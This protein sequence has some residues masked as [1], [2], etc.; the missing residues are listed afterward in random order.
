MKKIVF[1]SSNSKRRDKNSNCT[2]FPKWAEQWDDMAE[3]H[4]DCEVTLVVQLNGRYFLDICNGELIQKP[5]KVKLV[6]L[7]M[8]AKLPEFVEAVSAL[9]PDIAVAMTGPVSGY[10]WNGIRDASIAD[11]LRRKGIDTIC[12]PVE[13]ALDCF[14]KWR[15]HQVFVRH[16]F[17]TPHSL[18]IHHELF[19]SDKQSKTCTGN[20]YQEY[21][22]YEIQK[23]TM[24]VVI[25]STTGSSSMGIYVAKNYED[26]KKYLMSDQFMEDVIV[27]EFLDGDEYSAEVH[28]ARG[29][30]FV[31]PI[32]QVFDANGRGLKDPLGMTTLKYGPVM[33]AELHIEEIRRELL[34][35]AEIMDFSGIMNIDL[36]FVKGEWYIFEVNNRWSGVT[37]LTTASQGR[38]PYDV[39]M[40][41]VVGTEADYNDMSKMSFACQFKMPK[42]EPAVMAG[43]AKEPSVQSIIQYEVRPANKDPFWFNDVVIGGFPS[44]EKMTERFEQLSQKYPEQV[45]PKLVKALQETVNKER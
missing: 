25:K 11:A 1:Y 31:S 35:M 23:S 14:D 19:C 12:Y 36:I 13:T 15:S 5:K 8:E 10:D 24:P 29:R 41:E 38:L 40:D 27:Q 22:L 45:L 37:S 33:K 18:Y 42:A 26:A 43:L 9:A 6:T 20:V 34:R 3:R 17:Q 7:P 30:Y 32:Y 16:G 21:I 28:G 39:Y 2:V 4:P 44:V